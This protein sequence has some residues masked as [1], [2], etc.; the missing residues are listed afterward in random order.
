MNETTNNIPPQAAPKPATPMDCKAPC[1]GNAPKAPQAQPAG[2]S[3]KNIRR[4]GRKQ[5]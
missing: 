4:Q 3:P 2:A 1:C 5:H